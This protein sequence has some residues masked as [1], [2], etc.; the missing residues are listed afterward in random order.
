M[1]TPNSD[2]SWQALAAQAADEAPP[3]GID[4]VFSVRRQIEAEL[5]GQKNQSS[6]APRALDEI[7]TLMRGLWGTPALGA[8]A[9]ATLL[10]GWQLAPAVREVAI[11]LEFQSQLLIGL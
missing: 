10:L 4:V 9:V 1:A 7:A 6:T 2:K 5:A 11:A 8:A 3:S